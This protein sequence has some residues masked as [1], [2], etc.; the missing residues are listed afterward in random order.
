MNNSKN[1][2]ATL[3]LLF[4]PALLFAPKGGCGRECSMTGRDACDRE[5]GY[6]V[7]VGSSKDC[8][9]DDSWSCNVSCD[10][11]SNSYG[12]GGSYGSNSGGGRGGSGGGHV[13]AG[14]SG[15][16]LAY[17]QEE[18]R[19]QILSE[20]YIADN[21]K[22]CTK[23]QV[24][25]AAKELS[26]ALVDVLKDRHPLS[27]VMNQLLAPFFGEEPIPLDCAFAKK[28][29]IERCQ[30]ANNVSLQEFEAH[31]L[32][33]CYVISD[34]EGFPEKMCTKAQVLEA[35]K[36]TAALFAREAAGEISGAQAI[37]LLSDGLAAGLPLDCV[38]AERVKGIEQ[39]RAA[40]AKIK[41]E[42]DA[43]K[44]ALAQPAYL[45]HG[46]LSVATHIPGAGI[47]ELP[48][49]ERAA[50]IKQFGGERWAVRAI[51]LASGRCAYPNKMHFCYGANRNSP[52]LIAKYDAM[53]QEQVDAW[54]NDV[55]AL[56]RAERARGA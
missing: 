32:S 1:I 41:Q 19:E 44:D 23:A 31:D 40:A 21:G 10:R 55:L 29:A 16:A 50:L 24:I 34:G 43:R 39:C 26:G 11:E 13:V 45:S 38:L 46:T 8:N 28:A 22:I 54:G 4:I 2:F 7:C 15:V 25:A 35:Q 53:T 9:R 5:A 47:Y 37:A 30:V 52:H 51:E 3:L 49:A 27:L 12:G 6:S 17:A 14:L 48:A 42:I 33:E 18:V 36:M 20:C 56:I